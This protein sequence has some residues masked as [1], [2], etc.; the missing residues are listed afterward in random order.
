MNRPRQSCASRY[1]VVLGALWFGV[2]AGCDRDKIVDISPPS[3]SAANGS[4]T[5]TEASS[6]ASQDTPAATDDAAATATQTAGVA[7]AAPP[8]TPADAACRTEHGR[9]LTFYK[10]L[11]SDFSGI[12]KE[13]REQLV[14]QVFTMQQNARSFLAQCAVETRVGKELAPDVHFFLGKLLFLMSKIERQKVYNDLASKKLMGHA[15]QM[16]F[17]KR[18]REYYNEIV[19]ELGLALEGLPKAGDLRPDAL[20]VLGQ[21]CFEGELYTKAKSAYEKFLADYGDVDKHRDDAAAAHAALG[22]TLLS[23]EEY[24]PAAAILE[25]GWKSFPGTPT[26]PYFGEGTWKV[27]RAAG[28]LDGMARTVDRAL[29][30]LAKRLEQSAL[31]PQERQRI[32]TLHLYNEFRKGFVQQA[33]GDLEAAAASFRRHIARLDAYELERKT[34]PQAWEIYRRRSQAHLKFLN[35]LAGTPPPRDLDLG[36]GWITDEKLL[37]SEQ[38]GKVVAIVFRRLGDERS[39]RFL[40]PLSHI[41]AEEPDLDV[42]TISYLKHEQNVAEALVE[43]RSDLQSMA[44]LGPAGFDP[45]SVERSLFDAFHA[46]IGSATIVVIDRQGYPVWF[47]QDPHD[48]H[49]NMVKAIM[50]RLASS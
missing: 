3:R 46:T 17:Q 39:A 21:S 11:P 27:Y 5:T 45:D 42:V 26:G 34:L 40:A 20:L 32:E 37:L 9:L 7:E 44:Y 48:A 13:R 29:E 33:R 50:K 31:S 41:C 12:S 24:E 25:K 16:E 18:M 28:D 6:A 49:I 38:T 2:L 19:D 4:A 36:S 10:N 43:L 47:Q 23:L 22:K 1:G 15:F 35:E 30:D 8:D 14:S